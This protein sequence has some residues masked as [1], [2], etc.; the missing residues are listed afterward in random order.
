M[1]LYKYCIILLLLLLSEVCTG[2]SHSGSRGGSSGLAVRDETRKRFRFWIPNGSG[3]FALFSDFCK[4]ANRASNVTD[5]LYPFVAYKLIGFV[6][7]KETTSGKS[8]L[9]IQSGLPFKHQ[10]ENSQAG[11]LLH[12]V[13][14]CFYAVLHF[15]SVLCL[16]YFCS[17]GE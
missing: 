15:Y 3:E 2:Q 4:L 6:P 17:C 5:S 8:G 16:L 12:I 11:E 9:N 10:S 1:A 14:I 7:I 13:F